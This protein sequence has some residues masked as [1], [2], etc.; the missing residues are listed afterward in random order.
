MLFWASGIP[1]LRS[2]KPSTF[3]ERAQAAAQHMRDLS[4]KIEEIVSL[5]PGTVLGWLN[6]SKLQERADAAAKHMRY[7]RLFSERGSIN[8]LGASARRA[9]FEIIRDNAFEAELQWAATID[10]PDFT[11][12]VSYDPFEPVSVTANRASATSLASS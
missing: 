12:R 7:F 9:G 10:Y 3:R 1:M 8:E 4:P 6:P 5:P 11:Y 2:L